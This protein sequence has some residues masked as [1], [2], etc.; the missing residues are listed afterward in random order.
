MSK[1]SL[2]MALVFAVSL[3][4]L[5]QAQWFDSNYPF[6]RNLVLN[7][8]QG[9]TLHNEPL[10]YKTRSYNGFAG[11][12]L[13]FS[14]GQVPFVESAGLNNGGADYNDNVSMVMTDAPCGSGGNAIPLAI[15]RAISGQTLFYIVPYVNMTPYESKTFGVYYSNVSLPSYYKFGNARVNT[16][17]NPFQTSTFYLYNGNGIATSFSGLDGGFY[18]NWT[19]TGVEGSGF[20]FK[21]FSWFRNDAFYNAPFA[22]T[23]NNA[24]LQYP[25]DCNQ[26]PFNTTLVNSITCDNYANGEDVRFTFF[27]SLD[28]KGGKLLATYSTLVDGRSLFLFNNTFVPTFRFNHAAQMTDGLSSNNNAV[29]VKYSEAPNGGAS[30]LYLV[31]PTF[32]DRENSIRITTG[33]NYALGLNYTNIYGGVDAA[34]QVMLLGIDTAASSS[35]ADIDAGLDNQA[36]IFNETWPRNLSPYLGGELYQQDF[37]NPPAPTGRY[38]NIDPNYGLESSVQDSI[39]GVGQFTALVVDKAASSGN[40]RLAAL[41]ILGVILGA[42]ALYGASAGKGLKEIFKM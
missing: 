11:Y 12:T 1:F 7:E 8:T 14:T 36:K 4:G 25:S 28:G 16:E 34:N 39:S 5:A 29:A 41:G 26:I 23:S 21:G 37:P 31:T 3:A 17:Y 13:A 15:T 10:F 18:P 9:A 42:V 24:L 22:T 20:A 19:G 2:L 27:E 30:Y 33:T 35:D 32:I 6:C 38:Q 40:T